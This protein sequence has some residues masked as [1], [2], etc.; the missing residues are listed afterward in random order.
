MI[1]PPILTGSALTVYLIYQIVL[2]FLQFGGLPVYPSAHL[3][4]FGR[5]VRPLGHFS[6]KLSSLIILIRS[7]LFLSLTQ[8][9]TS[10]PLCLGN[11][12]TSGWI[13]LILVWSHRISENVRPNT[14]LRAAS[15][16]LPCTLVWVKKNLSPS[17][18]LLNWSA[19]NECF[20]W[21]MI[22]TW[23]GFEMNERM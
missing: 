8:G 11:L 1:D 19:E 15:D 2:P 5:L 22:R 17:L 10:L 9:A 18:S 3:S 20:V 13:F 21:N 7:S 16:K 6:I 4:H 14:Y 23:Y 12:K